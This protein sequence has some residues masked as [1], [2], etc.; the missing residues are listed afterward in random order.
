[1]LATKLYLDLDSSVCHQN[2]YKAMVLALYYAVGNRETIPYVR[3]VFFRS[4]ELKIKVQTHAHTKE[5]DVSFLLFAA[6]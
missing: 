5:T 2:T 6:F 4:D 3:G 1:M